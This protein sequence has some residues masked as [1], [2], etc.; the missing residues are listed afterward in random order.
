MLHPLSKPPITPTA[1]NEVDRDDTPP[2]THAYGRPP[3]QV[4]QLTTQE[5]TSHSRSTVGKTTK[6]IQ[7]QKSQGSSPNRTLRGAQ[8]LNLCSSRFP[9]ESV[10][11]RLLAAYL[12]CLTLWANNFLVLVKQIWRGFFQEQAVAHGK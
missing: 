6:A 8:P 12:S 7:P 5:S 3:L 1:G 11:S 9:N 4:Q 10:P 2:A